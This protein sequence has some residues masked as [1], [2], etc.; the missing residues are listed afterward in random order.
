MRPRACRACASRQLR[1]QVDAAPR[2]RRLREPRLL[3][4]TLRLERAN[5]VRVLER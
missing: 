2:E 4:Q 1:D 5:F 3:G